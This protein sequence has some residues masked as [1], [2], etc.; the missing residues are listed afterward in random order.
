MIERAPIGTLIIGYRFL[1][2]RKGPE[3]RGKKTLSNGFMCG[4]NSISVITSNNVGHRGCV[5]LPGRFSDIREDEHALSEVK[6]ERQ[7]GHLTER[8]HSVSSTDWWVG[9]ATASDS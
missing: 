8:E 3:R 7:L 5:A 2:N 1:R 4:G 9:P 6:P